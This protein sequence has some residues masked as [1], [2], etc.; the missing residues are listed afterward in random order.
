MDSLTCDYVIYMVHPSKK[1]KVTFNLL[2]S[3]GP[4]CP[5]SDVNVEEGFAIK[6]V[7]NGRSAVSQ[8]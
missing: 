1:S 6:D 4:D 8:S 5:E 3:A 2:E 7:Y